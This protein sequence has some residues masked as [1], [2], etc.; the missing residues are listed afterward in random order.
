M[1]PTLRGLFA[2]GVLAAALTLGGI[3]ASKASTVTHSDLAQ[4]LLGP[5]LSAAVISAV[6]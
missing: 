4:P 5:E 6:L 2:L 3:F 1:R